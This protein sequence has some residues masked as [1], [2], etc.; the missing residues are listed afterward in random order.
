MRRKLF[1]AMVMI[2]G[3][4]APAFGGAVIGNGLT[5]GSDIGGFSGTDTGVV[6]TDAQ[7]GSGYT[8]GQEV[9]G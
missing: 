5:G 1:I 9:S 7:S 6:V 4:T 2:V 3:L 8:D